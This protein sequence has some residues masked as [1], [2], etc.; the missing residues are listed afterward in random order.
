MLL[1]SSSIIL[2]QNV[3]FFFIRSSRNFLQA[4][5]FVMELERTDVFTDCEKVLFQQ[6]KKCIEMNL[7]PERSITILHKSIRI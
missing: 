7:I 1:E 2:Y 4:Y 3:N 6:N 5:I